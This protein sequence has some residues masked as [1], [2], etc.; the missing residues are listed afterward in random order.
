MKNKTLLEIFALS[1]FVKVLH[2]KGNMDL[3]A[4]E[5]KKIKESINC[6]IRK[7]TDSL[8]CMVSKKALDEVSKKQIIKNNKLVDLF[9]EN[10]DSQNKFDKGRK[11]FHYEHLL[12]VSDLLNMIIKTSNIGEIQEIL[13]Q[14]KVIWILKT[15][16]KILN[17][18]G[19]IKTR[20]N[21]IEAY[22]EAGI[23]IIEKKKSI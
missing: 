7:Y 15:E 20:K 18:L 22:R 10:W 5:V 3:N 11:I 21:P 23:E 13:K 17:N 2:L 12:T 9:D 6:D 16:N 14:A 1:L 19:Y 4:Y 8:P